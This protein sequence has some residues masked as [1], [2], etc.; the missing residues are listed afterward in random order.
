[1]MDCNKF[2]DSISNYLEGDLDS[3]IKAECAAHRLICRDCR[4]LYNDVRSTVQAL[5]GIVYSEAEPEG[6]KDRIIAAT[7]TGEMLSCNEFD[8]LLERYFDGVILA[9]TYQNFQ[10]HFEKCPKCRRLLAGIEDAVAM[11]RDAKSV[12]IAVPDSL[13]DRI[14]RATV[15]KKDSHWLGSV[16][17]LFLTLTNLM[18][19]PQMAAAGL[20]FAASSLFV[21]SRFGSVSGM[22]EHAEIKARRIVNEGEK[23]FNYTGAMA[24][25]GFRSVSHGVQSVLF[26]GEFVK[27]T[28]VKTR[29]LVI[30]PSPTPEPTDPPADEQDKLKSKSSGE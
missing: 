2:Q 12:E 5:N 18:W 9:P 26:S 22:A 10:S 21:I 29:P 17:N 30:E 1:M 4:E 25:T 7:T 14:V 20:I 8:K 3:R 27:P 6:L 15:G 23:R 16:K 24:R 19:T 13:H 11:C 28:K